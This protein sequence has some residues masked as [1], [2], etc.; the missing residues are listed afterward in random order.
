[1]KCGQE[2]EH[3]IVLSAVNGRQTKIL[4]LTQEQARRSWKLQKGNEDLLCI[5]SSQVIPSS[6][7]ITVRNVDRNQFEMQIYPAESV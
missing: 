2:K 1:M 6:E 4:L 5:T 7:E 3:L